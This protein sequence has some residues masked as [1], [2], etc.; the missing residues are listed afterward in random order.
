MARR[1]QWSEQVSHRFRRGFVVWAEKK[2]DALKLRF[3]Y[4]LG[5]CTSLPFL[6]YQL[7]TG[8]KAAI[9]VFKIRDPFSRTEMLSL[10]FKSRNENKFLIGH[11]HCVED[12]YNLRFSTGTTPDAFY[13]SLFFAEDSGS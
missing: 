11:P 6:D 5:I 3:I 4:C 1:D 12:L 7:C 13:F 2:E 10:S 8:G 9:A